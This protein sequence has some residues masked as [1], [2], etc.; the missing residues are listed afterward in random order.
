MSIGIE[1]ASAVFTIDV[2]SAIAIQSSGSDRPVFRRN[3]SNKDTESGCI[4][5]NNF[6]RPAPNIGVFVRTNAIL[7]NNI[8][9]EFKVVVGDMRG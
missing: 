5:P 9:S 8:A 1:V 2:Y 6:V 4:I 3:V 7:I